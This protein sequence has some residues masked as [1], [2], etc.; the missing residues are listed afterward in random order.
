MR[1]EN[2][3]LNC[4]SYFSD[5]DTHDNHDFELFLDGFIK[6]IINKWKQG[7]AP[8]TDNDYFISVYGLKTL[9]TSGLQ[10]RGKVIFVYIKYDRHSG[11]DKNHLSPQLWPRGNKI[12]NVRYTSS[13]FFHSCTYF[14]IFAT[15]Y[16]YTLI[17]MTLLWRTCWRR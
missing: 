4:D 2:W 9:V 3:K 1:V 13:T 11:T 16:P 10:L 15:I 14:D 7:K 6:I 12:T 5:I 8:T 17:S